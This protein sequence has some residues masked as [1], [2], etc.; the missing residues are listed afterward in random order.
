VTSEPLASRLVERL[1]SFERET[2][3]MAPTN[4]TSGGIDDTRLGGVPW[5]PHSEDRPRCRACSRY[6]AFMAQIALRDIPLLGSQMGLLSFHYCQQCAYGGN[7]SFGGES[8]R[9]KQGLYGGPG[10]DVRIFSSTLEGADDRRIVEPSPLPAL[11]V[12]MERKLEVPDALDLPEE[13]AA[14]LPPEYPYLADDFDEE[15]GGGLRHVRRSK[16]GGWPT[17]V[18]SSDWPIASNGQPALFAGQIDWQVGDQTPWCSGG[19]AYLFA[20]LAAEQP[21]GELLIQTT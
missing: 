19:Y 3:S 4:S 6:L 18:Q 7:M 15:V 21:V 17:W 16:A 1:R 14:L 11:L 12:S 8:L 5:W 20:D 2:S 10:Y 9:R 13:V